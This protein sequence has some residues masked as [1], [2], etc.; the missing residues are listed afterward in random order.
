M[1]NAFFNSQRSAVDR[2]SKDQSGRIDIYSQDNAFELTNV[3][4]GGTDQYKLDYARWESP[5]NQKKHWIVEGGVGKKWENLWIEFTPSASGTVLVNLR[6]S[7]YEDMQ[8]YH[9]DVWVDDFEV[10]GALVKNGSFEMIDPSGKPAYWGWTGSARQ[11]STDG[12][13]ARSGQCCVLVWHD[14]PLVQAI[15]VEANKTYRVSAWF[16]AWDK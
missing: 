1:L 8:Q 6:G 3:K 4:A 9:H 15:T 11:Y 14:L 12:S 2:V 7:F 13:Q 5:A 10:K 16:K